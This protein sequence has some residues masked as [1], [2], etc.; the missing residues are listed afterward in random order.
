MFQTEERRREWE[1]NWYKTI[2]K[3]KRTAANKRWERKK[4]DEFR[5]LK[6][7]LKCNRCP[8]NHIACLEFHHID[9]TEK[10]GNIGQIC[11]NYSTKR[12]LKEIEK[13]EILCANC[14]RK[15]HYKLIEIE[16]ADIA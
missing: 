7:K 13:C 8:E 4:M 6:A 14:H 11:R 12:L 15:E 16:N 3:E 9:P 1:R 5:A 2:G 10:E